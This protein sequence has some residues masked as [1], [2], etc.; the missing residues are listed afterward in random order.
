MSPIYT[1]DK[2]GFG[3][4]T[5]AEGGGGGDVYNNA[6]MLFTNCG[7]FGNAGPTLANATDEYRDQKFWTGNHYHFY[8]DPNTTY[9]DGGFIFVRTPQSG[10]YTFKIRGAY[11][12]PS[13]DWTNTQNKGGSPW[14]L[15]GEVDLV[16]G[17]WIGILVG[18]K[19]GEVRDSVNSGGGGGGGTF[20]FELDG[21]ESKSSISNSYIESASVTCLL[22]AAGGNGANWNSFNSSDTP[23]RDETGTGATDWILGSIN[24]GNSWGDNIFGRGAF[25]GSFMYTPYST[26]NVLIAGG[27]GSDAPLYTNY[28]NASGTEKRSGMPILNS[29]N[30]ISNLT[31]LGGIHWNTSDYNQRYNSY[32]RDPN[33]SSHGAIGG[34][35]GGAGGQYEGGGGGGYWGGAAWQHNQ[36]NTNYNYGAQSY[37]HPTRVT[38]QASRLYGDGGAGYGDSYSGMDKWSRTGR[39]YD[40]DYP[41]RESHGQLYLCP[42]EPKA[43]A[44]GEAVFHADG[45]AIGQDR[46]GVGKVTKYNW[47]VPEGVTSISAVCVGGGGSGMAEHDGGGGGGGALAYKNNIAVTPGQKIVVQVGN[48]GFHTRHSISQTSPKGTDSKI[49]VYPV[50]SGGG[51]GGSSYS[52]NFNGTN[53]LSVGA[54]NDLTM[55]TGDFTIECWVRFD[56]QNN[57]VGIWQLEGLTTNHTTTLA[58]AHNGSNWHGYRGGSTWNFGSTRSASQWYHCA[59]VRNSGTAT[60]YLDGT[61]LGTWSD[62]YNYQG[63][64]L[65]IGGYYTTGYR[66]NGNVSNFRVVKG[67]AL[68][69]SN[70]TP[71]TSALTTTSQGANSGNVKLLCCNKSTNTGKDVGPGIQDNGGTTAQ[72]AHPFTGGGSGGTDYA[73][74]GGGYG[75]YRSGQSCAPSQ[76]DMSKGMGGTYDQSNSDGGGDGGNGMQYSGCRQG[77]GGA[78]G[79]QGNGKN[80][81]GY[82]SNHN[83]SGCGGAAG[84]G[85]GGGGGAGANGTSDFYVGGGG[86]TGIYGLGADGAKG[87]ANQNGNPDGQAEDMVGKGGSPN[88][89]TGLNGYS[90]R[91]YQSEK[92][93]TPTG[94]GSVAQNTLGG[95][96]GYNRWRPNYGNAVGSTKNTGADGG[97]PG[98]GGGGANSGDIWGKGG[99]G[100]VRIIWGAPSGIQYRAFPS[101]FVDISTTYDSDADVFRIGSQPM[102]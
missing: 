7:A 31:G 79:Y 25:G 28:D 51:G 14:Y 67:Q 54:S 96:T 30:K 69:T 76:N 8:T 9:T 97:F 26:V 2:F 21:S 90:N 33:S 29:S 23:A 86:G 22:V 15:E 32:N 87:D 64:T 59:Y 83:Y 85:G 5:S 75:T 73:T 100:V 101:S 56:I 93:G 77:G 6:G 63:T 71:T 61:S 57:N 72:N 11:G 43:T 40:N 62:S 68:Y 92:G 34:Y 16:G 94:R 1:G 60:V 27:G 74:A 99:D 10:T 19:G 81:S 55:G 47:Y 35:G 91:S 37:V 53:H 4:S 17:R 36:Y 20:L 50:G 39:M 38:V 66:L 41:H 88:Q 45:N 48:G 98:G 52:V 84:H 24:A 49:T 3:A 58:F 13:P 80:H 102:Y 65:V 82:V 89:Y 42:K 18:Q 78:G 44:I 12:G 46:D 95:M 70:F